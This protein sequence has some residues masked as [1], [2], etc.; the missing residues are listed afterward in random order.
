MSFTPEHTLFRDNVRA[1]VE[2]EIAPNIN[3]LDEAQTFPRE[4][5]AR[6]SALGLLGLL[7]LGYPEAYGGHAVR[8]LVQTHRDRRDRACRQR[9]VDGEFVLAQHRPAADQ[10]AWQR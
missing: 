10:R 4:L 9:R 8:R 1:F 5:Y 7:D 2:R 6:A 3:A